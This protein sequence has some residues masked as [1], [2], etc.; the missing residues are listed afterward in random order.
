MT[1]LLLSE[2]PDDFALFAEDWMGR[3]PWDD[4]STWWGARSR[5]CVPLGALA[6]QH[7]VLDYIV[8]RIEPRTEW[9]TFIWNPLE[10]HWTI[11]CYW[12]DYAKD[13]DPREMCTDREVAKRIADR[14][15]AIRAAVLE[16]LL[17]GS[18]EPPAKADA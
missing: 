6:A 12:T 13:D 5:A 7:L 15:E 17:G 2:L 16:T 1:H 10:C 8:Q 14:A 18:Q 4:V 9:H 11:S 3:E